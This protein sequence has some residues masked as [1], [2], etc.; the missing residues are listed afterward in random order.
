MIL[1]VIKYRYFH[2]VLFTDDFTHVWWILFTGD[3]TRVWWI[4]FTGDFTRVWWILIILTP[5]TLTHSVTPLLPLKPFSPKSPLLLSYSFFL[6]VTHWALIL[7]PLWPCVEGAAYNMETA[8]RYKILLSPHHSF[9]STPGCLQ[10]YTT[11]LCASYPQNPVVYLKACWTVSKL[12]SESRRLF[13]SRERL[14]ERR[15]ASQCAPALDRSV[16]VHDES[17]VWGVLLGMLLTC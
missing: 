13:L 16:T 7:L 10:L 5:F 1:I 6:C 2:S 9:I 3:L 8:H 12:K 15:A 14:R 11:L 17:H 4:L